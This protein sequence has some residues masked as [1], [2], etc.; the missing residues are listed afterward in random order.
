MMYFDRL[1]FKI[2]F[3]KPYPGW[4]GFVQTTWP[5]RYTNITQRITAESVGKVIAAE[6]DAFF[7]LRA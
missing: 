4:T 2:Q 7:I 1:L 5:T 3:L 6:M